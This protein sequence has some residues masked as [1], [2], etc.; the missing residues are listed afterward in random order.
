MRYLLIA[1]LIAAPITSSAQGRINISRGSDD[2][3]KFSESYFHIDTVQA[4][5]GQV[6]EKKWL[7]R[8]CGGVVWKDRWFE[9]VRIQPADL[10]AKIFLPEVKPGDS[11]I[12]E[13]RVV[14]PV[15]P[16][17]YKRSWKMQQPYVEL[18]PF[19]D[20]LPLT[21]VIAVRSFD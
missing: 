14:A 12:F 3:M 4:T 9:S 5:P 7:L 21:L 10:V 15:P 20:V 19:G 1:L 13:P 16:G 18:N 17:F 6:V 11:V 8:N 2:C